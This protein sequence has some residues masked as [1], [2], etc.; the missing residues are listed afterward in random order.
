[1][2]KQKIDA[3]NEAKRIAK[4]QE[5]AQKA[6][7]GF[8]AQRRVYRKGVVNRCHPTRKVDENGQEVGEEESKYNL[9]DNVIEIEEYNPVVKKTTE[10]FTTEKPDDILDELVGYFEENGYKPELAKNKYKLKV[11]VLKEEKKDDGKT[12]LT[13]VGM[14]INITKAA[15]DKY[16]VEFIRT[17]GD[18][19]DFF[20]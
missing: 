12:E 3:D 15:A 7:G 19:F 16:C 6:N 5:R 1:M 9:E 18:Q 17:D 20:K 10:F 13:T 2:R 11:Q 14:N 8:A 4:E